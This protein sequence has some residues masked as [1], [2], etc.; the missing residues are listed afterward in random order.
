MLD[1]IL[2]ANL[3]QETH[4]STMGSKHYKI[5]NPLWE[6]LQDSN[7]R[8]SHSPKCRRRHAWLTRALLAADG[9]TGRDSFEAQ[10]A[11]GA[12]CESGCIVRSNGYVEYSPASNNPGAHCLV[13]NGLIP[14]DHGLSSETTSGLKNRR[15]NT[16]AI[17][18]L[19]HVVAQNSIPIAF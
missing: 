17:K 11:S 5:L 4:F 18:A 13:G 12:T 19:I 2:A 7:T 14:E 8:G 3:K 16:L 1:A 6:P 10:A 9:Q 15:C